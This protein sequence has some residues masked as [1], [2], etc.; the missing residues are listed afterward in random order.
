MEIPFTPLL[1]DAG[2]DWLTVTTTDKIRGKRMAQRAMRLLSQEVKMGNKSKPWSMS[3]YQGFASGSVQT[4]ERRDGIIVRLGSS[5]A[6]T[7]WRRFYEESENC[8]RI[9]VQ[10][11]V[12]DGSSPT[13]TLAKEWRRLRKFWKGNGRAPAVSYFHSSDGSGT[14]YLCKRSSEMFGR[15]YDKGAESKLDH[16]KGALRWEIE[17]KG[18][19]ARQIAKLMAES[20]NVQYDACCLVSTFFGARGCSC[21]SLDLARDSAASVGIQ[22]MAYSIP[23]LRRLASD[24]GRLLRWIHDCVRPSIQDLIGRGKS[25]D[26]AHA[27]GLDHTTLKSAECENSSS[28]VAA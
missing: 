4:G 18:D 16:Y 8:S 27:L 20:S 13:A 12:V 17:C 7:E 21:K 14:L 24:D 19:R 15:V 1:L 28:S 11:T 10:C 9:D 25:Y 3:G 23:A 2:V 5:V 22:R 26:V 6:R